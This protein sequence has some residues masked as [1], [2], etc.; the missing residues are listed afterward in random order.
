ML[1][2][3]QGLTVEAQ[4]YNIMIATCVKM[5]QPQNALAIYQRWGVPAPT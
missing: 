1:P 5:G 4:T 2:M 3:A